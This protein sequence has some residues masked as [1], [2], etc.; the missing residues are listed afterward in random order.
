MSF[1]HP[2]KQKLRTFNW[3]QPLSAVFSPIQNTQLDDHATS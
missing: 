1:A 2:S 3:P